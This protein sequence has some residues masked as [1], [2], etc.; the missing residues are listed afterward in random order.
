MTLRTEKY[1]VYRSVR[2]AGIVGL[3]FLVVNVNSDLCWTCVEEIFY[4]LCYFYHQDDT[5]LHTPIR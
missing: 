4:D 1:T 2:S 3:V 5:Q